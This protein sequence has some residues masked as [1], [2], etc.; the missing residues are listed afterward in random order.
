MY[1]DKRRNFVCPNTPCEER[2]KGIGVPKIHAWAFAFQCQ[3]VIR[4]NTADAVCMF[5]RMCHMQALTRTV[6]HTKRLCRLNH[7]T[8]QPETKQVGAQQNSAATRASC[9]TFPFFGVVESV[10]CVNT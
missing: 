1:R 6:M 2:R 7:C 3:G 9:E 8:I 10:V 4:F 5:G